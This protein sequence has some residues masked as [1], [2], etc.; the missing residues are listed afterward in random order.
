MSWQFQLDEISKD[1]LR[2]TY[3]DG[4]HRMLTFGE[5][6]NLWAQPADLFRAFHSQILSDIPFSA[7]KWETPVL[8]T[9]RLERLFEFVALN[10][11]RLDR[12][13]NSTAFENQFAASS[14]DGSAIAFA[15]IGKNAILVAPR[16]S[17]PDVN[18]CHL[19][20]YLRTCSAAD[21]SS[22]WQV[23]G[24]SMLERVSDKPVWLST[25]GGGVAW[26]HVR[27]DDRPKYYGYRPYKS[28]E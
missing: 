9:N 1:V 14:E 6:L 19:A 15:N 21:E 5:V 18:H 28:G 24:K 11:P 4:D 10:S 20:S 25:A 16:P 27:L 12:S 23:V 2:Y 7:Y 13:E 17:G 22:L 3:V 26:L 8:D